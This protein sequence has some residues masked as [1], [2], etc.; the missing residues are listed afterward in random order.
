MHCSYA[1]LPYIYSIFKAFPEE[2]WPESKK[3]NEK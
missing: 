2:L 1:T 3:Y